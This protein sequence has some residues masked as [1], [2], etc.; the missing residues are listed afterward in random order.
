MTALQDWGLSIRPVD[1]KGLK[2]IICDALRSLTGDEPAKAQE[3]QLTP[4]RGVER[5]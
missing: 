1:P 4:H 3:P 2:A 5:C